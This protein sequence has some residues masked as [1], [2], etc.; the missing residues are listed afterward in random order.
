[1][2]I[3]TLAAMSFVMFAPVG[4]SGQSVASPPAFEVVSIRPAGPPP[5]RLGRGVFPFPGGRIEAYGLKLERLIEEAFSVQAFQVSGGPRWI[6]EDR[7]DI[8]AKP[9]A[10]SS[11]SKSNPSSPIT[12]I[13]DEQRQMP[14]QMLSLVQSMTAPGARP[15]DTHIE[16]RT[17]RSTDVGRGFPR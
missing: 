2:R 11:S 1:M 5:A 17:G 16:L 12:P 7:Y 6:Y 3:S 9:P 13:N 14:R 15:A 8:V 4:S 10:T